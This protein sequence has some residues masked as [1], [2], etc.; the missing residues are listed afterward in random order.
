MIVVDARLCQKG[1]KWRKTDLAAKRS[2]VGFGS[3]P[4]Y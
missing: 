4:D 2:K 3:E 1:R